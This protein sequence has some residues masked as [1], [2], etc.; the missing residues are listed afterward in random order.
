MGAL[1]FGYKAYKLHQHPKDDKEADQEAEEKF[2]DKRATQKVLATVLIS[3]FP[4]VIA[5]L[6]NQY[7]RDYVPLCIRGFNT[8]HRTSASSIK[9]VKGI[10][11]IVDTALHDKADLQNSRMQHDALSVETLTIMA[12]HIG[13][14]KEI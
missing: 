14:Y 10:S 7:G 12:R 8:L 2:E 11:A 13:N 6:V 3:I 5:D 1:F 4:S 9:I